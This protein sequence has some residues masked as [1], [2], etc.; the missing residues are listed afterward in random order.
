MGFH[1]AFRQDELPGAINSGAHPF[2]DV[3]AITLCCGHPCR[4]RWQRPRAVA[5]CS[6]AAWYLPRSI[7]GTGALAPSFTVPYLGHKGHHPG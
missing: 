3:V 4:V 2:R 6:G 1:G 5:T 7:R